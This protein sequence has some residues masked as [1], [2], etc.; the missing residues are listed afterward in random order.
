[1]LLLKRG[2][3]LR[4]FPQFTGLGQN[5]NIQDGDYNALLAKLEKRFSKGISFLASYTWAKAI[6]NVSS[7]TGG[8]GRQEMPGF[9]TNTAFPAIAVGRPRITPSGSSIAPSMN[10]RS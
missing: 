4:P 3:F 10:F 2:T 1:M 6:D 9:S 5:A 8:I 7:G